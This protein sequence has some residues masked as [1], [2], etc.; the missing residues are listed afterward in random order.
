M[1][2]SNSKGLPQLTDEQA[3]ALD[4]VHFTALKHALVLTLEKGDLCYLNNMGCLHGREVFE[5]AGNEYRHLMRIWLRDPIR[6]YACKALGTK[7]MERTGR[8]MVVGP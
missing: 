1:C 6:S 8:S 3:E 5:N 4:L 7:S 2:H